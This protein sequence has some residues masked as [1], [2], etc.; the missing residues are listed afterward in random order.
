MEKLLKPDDVSDIIDELVE[1][2]NHSYVLGLKLR[3]SPHV[4]EAIHCNYLDPMEHLVHIIYNF[5]IQTEPIPIW[6]VILE[7]LR[8]PVVNFPV[9]AKRVEAVHFPDPTATCDVVA[10]TTGM[11]PSGP[12]ISDWCSYVSIICSRLCCW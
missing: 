9:L 4:V 2:S 8:H 3:L 7:A 12:L 6:R 10:E 5:T 11:L 1:A